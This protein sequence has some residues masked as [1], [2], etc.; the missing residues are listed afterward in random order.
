[1]SCRIDAL[2]QHISDVNAESRR[3]ATPAGIQLNNNPS[4]LVMQA[5]TQARWR[6]TWRADTTSHD[7]FDNAAVSRRFAT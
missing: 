7:F 1:V 6:E 3:H 5:S 4:L 2:Y